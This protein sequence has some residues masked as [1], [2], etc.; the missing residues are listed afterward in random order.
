MTF[1]FTF[2]APSGD[3][4]GTVTQQVTVGAPD[5]NEVFQV[6]YS[7]AEQVGGYGYTLSVG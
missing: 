7:T 4:M 3:P 6:E 2:Y 5:M 1:T